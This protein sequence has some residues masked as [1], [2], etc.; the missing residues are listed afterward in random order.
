[1]SW[2]GSAPV[3]SDAARLFG[4]LT[5]GH[6]LRV[7]LDR[8]ARQIIVQ[9][10][11]RHLAF[12][13]PVHL[14][15]DDLGMVQAADRNRNPCRVQVSECQRRAARAA[16]PTLGKRGR[17]VKSWRAARER[18]GRYRQR[19]EYGEHVAERALA[20]AAVAVVYIAG[21]FRALVADGIA[22]A[23]SNQSSRRYRHRSSPIWLT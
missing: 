22:Q 18:Q 13:A 17:S 10:E 14:G 21:R 2:P 15:P 6:V 23:A 12:D 16:E 3:R 7:A 8:F 5:P 9:G 4:R 1:M 11:P 19:S 20:Q